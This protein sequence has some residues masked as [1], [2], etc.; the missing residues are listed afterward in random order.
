MLHTWQRMCS[1]VH[2]RRVWGEPSRRDLFDLE[3][4]DA[5]ENLLGLSCLKLL[6]PCVITLLSLQTSF[7]GELCGQT[8][9]KGHILAHSQLCL[10]LSL[11]SW[12]LAGAYQWL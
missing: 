9:K 6:V 4:G 10:L 12:T 11:V 2:Q 7:C 3:G 5:L 8:G 1:A